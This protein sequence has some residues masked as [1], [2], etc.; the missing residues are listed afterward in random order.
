MPAAR[1]PPRVCARNAERAE[2]RCSGLWWLTH[3]RTAS[4]GATGVT[5][6][7]DPSAIDSPAAAISANGLSVI[8]RC[9]PR[10][11]AYMPLVPPHS[12]SK[13]GCTLATTPSRTS[14]AI[15]SAST[16]SRCSSR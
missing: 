3:A 9:G 4:H 15:P 10:R 12:A 13:A 6:L 1:Q 8:A 5:G 16:I 11:A 7:S 14:A 2:I